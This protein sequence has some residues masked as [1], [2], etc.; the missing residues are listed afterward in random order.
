MSKSYNSAINQIQRIID[1]AWD[2][3]SDYIGEYNLQTPLSYQQ[4]EEIF[5]ILNK[6]SKYTEYK[7][8]ILKSFRYDS[9]SWPLVER[10]KNTLK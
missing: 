10:E 7:S 6:D 9:Y 2:K 8:Q 3:F 1:D 4:F 5:E